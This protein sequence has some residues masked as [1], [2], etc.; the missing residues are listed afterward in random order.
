MRPWLMLE[1]K[2]PFSLCPH[3]LQQNSSI[4]NPYPSPNVPPFMNLLACSTHTSR[5]AY[6][7]YILEQV[8][9]VG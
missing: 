4:P 3:P 8:L 6:A 2:G 7:A 9:K 5:R 1:S